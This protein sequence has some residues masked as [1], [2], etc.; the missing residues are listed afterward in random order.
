MG[1]NLFIDDYTITGN[2]FG[3]G[4]FK[5]M[6]SS[7]PTAAWEG[8]FFRI[9]DQFC[10]VVGKRFSD[11]V[12]FI[13]RDWDNPHVF[14]FFVWGGADVEGVIFSHAGVANMDS[15][16]WVFAQ[17]GCHGCIFLPNLYGY[18]SGEMTATGGGRA[19]KIFIFD[20]N[21]WFGGYGGPSG[22]SPGFSAFQYSETGN[23][24]PGQLKSFRSNILWN[25]ELAGKQGIFCKACDVHSMTK[26][27]AAGPPVEEDVGDPKDLDYNDGWN[28][29][30]DAAVD[31]P[32]KGHYHNW[33]NG[34]I[35]NWSKTPG[36]HDL[37]VDPAFVDYQR[38]V[39]L[40]ATKCLGKK[41]SRAGVEPRSRRRRMRW[42]IRWCMRRGFCVGAAGDVSLRW[43]RGEPGAGGGNAEEGG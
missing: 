3:G 11:A 39:E 36:E 2:Y 18:S 6:Y 43:G 7:G 41:A 35:G 12:I 29:S 14:F 31:F 10:W 8:N 40:F 32:N 21:T 26:D 42:G 38:D 23:N 4:F 33:G 15:G 13:D 17:P 19:G 30:K 25:P 24:T 27:Q 5:A 1:K 20:H 16:E 28:C 22:T 9:F 34:Y 37:D